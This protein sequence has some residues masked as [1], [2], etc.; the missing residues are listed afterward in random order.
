[1][2]L[3]TDEHGVIRVGGT[4]VTLDT[5]VEAF[6]EGL[7]AEAIVDQY[8]TLKLADVYSVIGYLLN[9]REAVAEY[10]QRQA[11]ETADV[12]RLVE[13][14]FPPEGIRARLLARQREG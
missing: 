7:S 2:P 6:G 3:A 8:P 1:M 12:R 11:H 14:L 5:V 4:R 13:G 10:M 9:H